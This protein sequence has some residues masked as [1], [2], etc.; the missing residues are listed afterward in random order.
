MEEMG[1]KATRAPGP[2]SD[3]FSA[4]RAA[5]SAEQ[6]HR[7]AKT[8]FGLS[9]P[10]EIGALL[11]KMERGELVDK[12]SSEMM[13]SMMRGQIYRTRIPRYLGYRFPIPHKTGDFLPYIGNDVGVLEMPGRTVV[14]SIFT[15]NHFGAADRL[16]DTIG[17]IAEQTANY[18]GYRQ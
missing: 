10:H 12:A 3:W 6:F 18:F 11:E 1:L 4:L 2:A 8:P 16:E 7:D 13:L 9:T 14:L 15:A 5:S 17:R